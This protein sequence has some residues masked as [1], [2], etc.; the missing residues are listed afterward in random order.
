METKWIVIMVVGLA[1]AMF[2]PMI[3]S[4]RGKAECRV[5]DIKAGMPADDIIKLCK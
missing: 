1:V 3:F 5:E 2:T 4:E